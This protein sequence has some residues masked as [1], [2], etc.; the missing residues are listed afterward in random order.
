[1]KKSPV[2]LDLTKISLPVTAFVSIIH[3]VSGVGLYILSPFWLIALY[4]LSVGKSLINP[5]YMK[6]ALWL[7]MVAYL[8][9]FTAGVR[10]MIEDLSTHHGVIASRCSA[11]AVLIIWALLAVILTVRM[12]V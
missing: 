12:W 5:L 8:Y 3:R 6:V 11:W 7:S 2:F 10:H 1:M 9:H 4:Q